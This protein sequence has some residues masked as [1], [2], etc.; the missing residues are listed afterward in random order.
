MNPSKR[1][2]TAFETLVVRYLQDHGFPYAERRALAGN[3][4]KGD[5][6]GVPGIALECKATKAFTASTFVDE[7]NI[8]AHNAGVP[9][10]VAIVKRRGKGAGDAYVLMDLETFTELIR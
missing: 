5:I 6:A 4:D 7:A 9:T 3:A 8:E 1:K 2:G 10:G